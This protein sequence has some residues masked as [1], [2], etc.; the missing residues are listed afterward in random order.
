MEALAAEAVAA[1]GSA[2]H[3][4]ETTMRRSLKRH[5]NTKR[6]MQTSTKKIQLASCQRS[7]CHAGSSETHSMSQQR[8]HSRASSSWRVPLA[9]MSLRSGRAGGGGTGPNGHVVGV[10]TMEIAREIAEGR[11][12]GEGRL[13]RRPMIRSMGEGSTSEVLE[14]AGCRLGEGGRGGG[15]LS[16]A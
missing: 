3:V 14:A 6:Q 8:E 5:Q 1:A 9:Q 2:W 11:S 7:A 13:G 16:F 4:T 12:E 10:E 15:E